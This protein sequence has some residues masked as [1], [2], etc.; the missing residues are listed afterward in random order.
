MR[1]LILA[2]SLSTT[3]AVVAQDSGFGL[4]A[5]LGDPTGINA[6]L[7]MGDDRALA[8]GLAWGVWHNGYVHLH[9]DHLFH[10]MD[11]LSVS[12][13]RLPLYYGPGLRIR[14][15]NGDGYWHRGHYYDQ[16]GTRV[17]V[18]VRFPVG[19]AYLFDGAPVDVFVEAVPTLNL[20]PATSFD[21]DGGIG[22]RYWFR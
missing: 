5:M 16:D 13:G 2:L 18:G 3:V 12:S 6:K 19:L 11:L 8:F 10:N 17:D 7:W 20:I 1:A 22:V 21:L 15:W 9:A 4:G 14:S